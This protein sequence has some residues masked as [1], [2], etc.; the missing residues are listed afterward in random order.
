MVATYPYDY[1][2]TDAA[3]G[4]TAGLFSSM[5]FIIYACIILAWIPVAVFEIIGMWKM[6]KKAGRNGWEAIIPFYNMWTFFEISGYPGSKIFFIFIPYAGPIIY[7]VFLI[8]ASISLAQKFKKSG[9]FTALLILLPVIGYCILGFNGDKY[10]SS[11]GKQ[12][13]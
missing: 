1:S 9:G 13:Q 10:Y 3:L 7:L 12:R 2:S 6:F 4:V 5:I 11:L 8:K